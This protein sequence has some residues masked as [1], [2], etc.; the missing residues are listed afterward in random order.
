MLSKLGSGSGPDDAI[1][2]SNTSLPLKPHPH[3]HPGRAYAACTPIN[4]NISV[5]EQSDTRETA[6]RI[7][8]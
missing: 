7:L 1:L 5:F 2:L 4:D 3:A 8:G 6:S